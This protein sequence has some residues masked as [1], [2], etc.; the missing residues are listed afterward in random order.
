MSYEVIFLSP[1]AE[2]VEE[3]FTWYENKKSGLGAEFL[4]EVE[5][6]L[7]IIQNNP[8]LFEAHIN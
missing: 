4:A 8:Y 7:E 1:A 6:Y 5:G 2:E 3:A